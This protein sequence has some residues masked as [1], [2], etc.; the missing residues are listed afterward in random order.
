MSLTTRTHPAT[1]SAPP[2]MTYSTEISRFL[3]AAFTLSVVHADAWISGLQDDLVHRDHAGGWGWTLSA[4][5]LPLA[6]REYRVVR[7]AARS[8][9]VPLLDV[10]VFDH[11]TTFELA[12]DDVRLV[13][14]R[15]GHRPARRPPFY[16][17]AMRL[18]RDQVAAP[19]PAAPLIRGRQGLG[20]RQSAASPAGAQL[21]TRSRSLSGEAGPVRAD[22]QP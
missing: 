18:R 21:H 7:V 16:L 20:S 2:R 10:S 11:P 13:R 12:A 6:R 19:G 8:H 15:R 22:P 5:G 14:E 17:A 3:V 4:S 9:L 1:T